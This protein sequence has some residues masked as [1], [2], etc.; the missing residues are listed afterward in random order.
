MAQAAEQHTPTYNWSLGEAFRYLTRAVRLPDSVALYEMEQLRVEVQKYVD[1][2]PQGEPE[3]LYKNFKLRR[4]RH[5]VVVEGIRW[6]SRCKVAEQDVRAIQSAHAVQ[7]S[8]KQDK[9]KAEGWQVRHLR[10][11][12][13][14]KYPPDGHPP[15]DMTLTAILNSVDGIFKRQGWKLASPDTLARVMGRRA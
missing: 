1:G 6:D 15:V 14:E 12:L 3:Y 2:K 5:G 9:P 10:E 11:A 7:P 4:D 13:K 8:Q